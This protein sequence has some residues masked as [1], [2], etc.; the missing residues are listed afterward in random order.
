MRRVGGG[1]RR[2]AQEE[3]RNERQKTVCKGN[4]QVRE[5]GKAKTQTQR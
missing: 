2:E 3:I 4:E 5:G 1:T